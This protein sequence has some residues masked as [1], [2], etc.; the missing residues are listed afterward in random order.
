MKFKKLSTSFFKISFTGLTF[1]FLYFLENPF[2]F[3]I[4][5]T[6]SLIQFYNLQNDCGYHKRVKG[7]TVS[8]FSNILSRSFLIRKNNKLFITFTLGFFVETPLY[9]PK[10]KHTKDI[11]TTLQFCTRHNS[12]VFR[13]KKKVNSNY[14]FTRIQSCPS[15]LFQ[16]EQFQNSLPKHKVPNKQI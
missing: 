13:E 11:K 5:N 16:K 4:D 6:K 7:G 14:G 1:T 10:T 15:S 2:F 3:N 12:H 8:Y 9:Q